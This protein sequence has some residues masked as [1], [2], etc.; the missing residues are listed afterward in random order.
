MVHH[1]VQPHVQGDCQ[2]LNSAE[3][4]GSL[5]AAAGTSP[6]PPAVVT[7]VVTAAAA[8]PTGPQTVA[9]VGAAVG[10]A[11]GGAAVLGLGLAAYVL[12]KRRRSGGGT[13]A[14]VGGK[15]DAGGGAGVGGG[16]GQVLVSA[17]GRVGFS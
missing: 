10:G 6:P 3:R 5:C 11:V 15:G 14:G 17:T 13:R 2:H 4:P 9:L 12:V 16:S 8:A 7:P 1:G